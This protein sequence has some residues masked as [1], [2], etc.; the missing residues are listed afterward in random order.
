MNC[1][2]TSMVGAAAG[3]GAGHM[4]NKRLV[5]DLCEKR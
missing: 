5:D 2:L 1:K 3:A 4:Y